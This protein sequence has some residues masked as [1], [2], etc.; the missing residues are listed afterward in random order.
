LVADAVSY[1][2]S[3]TVELGVPAGLLGAVIGGGAG[4]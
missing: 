3:A 2:A 1:V 4:A